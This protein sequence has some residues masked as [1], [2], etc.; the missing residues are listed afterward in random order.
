MEASGNPE[1]AINE[2]VTSVPPCILKIP[3]RGMVSPQPSGAK[4]WGPPKKA[5]ATLCNTIPFLVHGT[6][7]PS[8]TLVYMDCL[9]EASENSLQPSLPSHRP[10]PPTPEDSQ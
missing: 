3:K 10:H 7:Y 6:S 4:C 8:F 2:G 9:N 5:E 1:D